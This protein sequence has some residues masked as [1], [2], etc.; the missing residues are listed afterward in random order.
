MQVDL[1]AEGRVLRANEVEGADELQDAALGVVLG[2]AIDERLDEPVALSLVSY[3]PSQHGSRV[4]AVTSRGSRLERTEATHDWDADRVEPVGD[5]QRRVRL[6]EPRV[7]VL[8]KDRVGL[9][10]TELL[11]ELVL[12]QDAFRAVAA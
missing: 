5:E 10:L 11:D 7:P 6:V 2:R 9:G 8:G 3:P 12:R 4:D 1:G